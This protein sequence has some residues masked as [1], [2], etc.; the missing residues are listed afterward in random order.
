MTSF[1]LHGGACIQKDII[2]AHCCLFLFQPQ[3]TNLEVISHHFTMFAHQCGCQPDSATMD[4]FGHKLLV[5]ISQY[6]TTK[7]PACASQLCC[8]SH[9]CS[10]LTSL[11]PS[12]SPSCPLLAPFCHLVSG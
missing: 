3:W 1:C 10:L 2:S 11:L 6:S 12:L 5:I 9:H 4:K 8:S 7:P